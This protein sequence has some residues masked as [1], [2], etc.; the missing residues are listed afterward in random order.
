MTVI[1]AFYN[2]KPCCDKKSNTV[3]SLILAETESPIRAKHNINQ[4]HLL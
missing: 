1:K 2:D 4:R 3:G